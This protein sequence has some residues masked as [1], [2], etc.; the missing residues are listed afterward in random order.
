MNLTLAPADPAHWM[1]Q[2]S[3]ARDQA[4]GLRK[5]AA[6]LEQDEELAELLAVLDRDR[7]PA[8][9]SADQLYAAA[10]DAIHDAMT[11]EATALY[12]RRAPGGPVDCTCG[13]A[14]GNHSFKLTAVQTLPCRQECDCR[15]YQAAQGSR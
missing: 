1:G 14:Q 5:L 10:A 11:W 6:L 9:I 12:R 3:A 8:H 7:L 15:D 2:A 13:H 4:G